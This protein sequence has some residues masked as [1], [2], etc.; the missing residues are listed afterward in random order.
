MADEDLKDMKNRKAYKDQRCLLLDL[1]AKRRIGS[2]T[3]PALVSIRKDLIEQNPL[4]M[5]EVSLAIDLVKN[6]PEKQVAEEGVYLH[7]G[8]I[9]RVAVSKR[10]YRYAQKLRDL[11]NPPVSRVHHNWDFAPGEVF[12]LSSEE[13]LSTDQIEDYSQQYGCCLMCGCGPRKKTDKVI[14]P[15]CR[16]ALNKLRKQEQE[17]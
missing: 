10:G 5:R 13:R 16:T 3:V 12:V 8:A 1:L 4:T 2:D 7:N 11:L 17:D 14:G 6:L 15:E 9:Y